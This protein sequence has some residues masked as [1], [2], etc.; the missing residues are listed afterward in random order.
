MRSLCVRAGGDNFQLFAMSAYLFFRLCKSRPVELLYLPSRRGRKIDVIPEL[1]VCQNFRFAWLPTILEW[2]TT[3]IDLHITE[4]NIQQTDGDAHS[5]SRTHENTA[6]P[7]WT[8]LS[9]DRQTTHGTQISG[10]LSKKYINDFQ[11]MKQLYSSGHDVVAPSGKVYTTWD[12]TNRPL[13]QFES[14]LSR[15]MFSDFHD[16]GPLIDVGIFPMSDHVS[17]ARDSDCCNPKLSFQL[18]NM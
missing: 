6:L 7:H 12:A 4:L 10:N 2:L 3:S 8:E 9:F 17:S 18:R 5:T 15:L 14:L 11:T 13:Q 16:C 1:V